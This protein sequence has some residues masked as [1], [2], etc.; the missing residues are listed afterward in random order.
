MRTRFL[1]SD[2]MVRRM[3]PALMAVLI[4]LGSITWSSQAEAGGFLSRLRG[5]M[6]RSPAPAQ[7]TTVT[8]RSQR[9]PTR[10]LDRGRTRLPSG[11]SYYQ[12]RYY[13][14]FNNRFYGP[15]YGYF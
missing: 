7:R 8:P 13:G 2:E 14:N 6:Q 12:G 15:Q 5:T 10:D 11:R 9:Y 4:V 3:R 1:W